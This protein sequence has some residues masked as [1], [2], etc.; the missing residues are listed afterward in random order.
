MW[1]VFMMST[2]DDAQAAPYRL[3]TPRCGVLHAPLYGAS[4]AH[5][6]ALPVCTRDKLCATLFDYCFIHGCKTYATHP[7]IFH[8]HHRVHCGVAQHH[9]APCEVPCS[10]VY[11]C[12]VACAVCQ[13]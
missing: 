5:A 1:D 3:L 11:A 8:F 10:P 7:Y 13:R 6:T 9:N 4:N 2:N 12:S